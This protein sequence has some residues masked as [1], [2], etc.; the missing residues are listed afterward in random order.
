MSPWLHPAGL[1]LG[2][3]GTTMARYRL[4]DEP[5]SRLAVWARRFALF[6][7]PAAVLS[8]II[9]RAGLLDLVPALVTFAG[10]LVLA[11]GAI[12]LALAAFVV[13]WKDGSAGFGHALLA[14]LIGVSL[15]AYPAYF[16][17]KAYRV[18]VI[19]DITTDPIDPPRFEAI[20]RLRSRDTN[21]VEYAGLYVAEQQRAAYPDIE[22]LET[23][24]DVRGLYDS[25]LAVI[26]KRKWLV[27]DERPPLPGRRDGLIEAVARTP[28]MGFRDDVVVRVRAVAA[29]SRL[30]VRSA[31]RYGRTDFGTNAARV[32]NLIDD[33]D[34]GLEVE[35][36]PKPVQKA[37]A[38]PPPAKAGQP[39][40]AKR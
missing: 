23:T 6:A 27:L 4:T 38:A 1:D 8:I 21:P 12:V 25:A 18:P 16:A 9:V 28:I 17:V 30:D 2:V 31:S 24:S 3:W 7:L 39:A 40:T 22:P 5:I 19:A 20:A 13:I 29:G 37:K 32:R 10:A 14:A 15:I 33:I 11:V 26:K 36:T 34:D 35:K